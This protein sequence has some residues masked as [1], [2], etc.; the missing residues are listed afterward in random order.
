M[1]GLVHTASY[2]AGGAAPASSQC[3]Y[4]DAA[5]ATLFAAAA[6]ITAALVIY[7]C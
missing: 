6:A 5:T 4:L 7:L 2:S 3:L 1:G